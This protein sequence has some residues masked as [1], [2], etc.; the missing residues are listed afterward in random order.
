MQN[1]VID[2]V[3]SRRRKWGV[4]AFGLC[5]AGHIA[6]SFSG[7]LKIIWLLCVLGSFAWA[8]R[9]SPL[10]VQRLAVDTQGFAVIFVRDVAWEAELLSGSLVSRTLCLLHWRTN[11]GMLWQCVLPDSVSHENYRRI[12]V[13]ARWGQPSLAQRERWSRERTTQ[14][15]AA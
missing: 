9:E 7:S 15:D 4:A 2:F 1:F 10:F 3:P 11:Q 12:L 6:L 13:W 8:W 5:I 14:E